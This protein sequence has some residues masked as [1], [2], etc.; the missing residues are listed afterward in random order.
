M[1]EEGSDDLEPDQIGQ[2]VAAHDAVHVVLKRTVSVSGK[3]PVFKATRHDI[4]LPEGFW[5]SWLC[6]LFWLKGKHARSSQG[7]GSGPRAG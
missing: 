5:T 1:R 2:S 4:L 3:G 6:D 7:R